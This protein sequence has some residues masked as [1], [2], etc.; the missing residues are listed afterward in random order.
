MSELEEVFTTGKVKFYHAE[1]VEKL[2]AELEILRS[3]TQW[4]TGVPE[5]DGEYLCKITRA[6]KYIGRVVASIRNGLWCTAY[7]VLAW[8]YLPEEE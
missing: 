1:Y 7:D 6:N 8:A 4:H 3:R 5:K 2:K